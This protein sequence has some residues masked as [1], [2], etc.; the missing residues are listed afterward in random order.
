MADILFISHSA[1]LSGAPVCLLLLAREMAR[2]GHGV[3]FG[4]PAGGP[5]FDRYPEA[6]PTRFFGRSPGRLVAGIRPDLVHVNTVVPV[7][8]ARAARKAGIPVVWHIHETPAGMKSSQKRAL[9][10]MAGAV[11]VPSRDLAWEMAAYKLARPENIHA[12]HNG[13]A[14]G[15]FVPAKASRQS[16]RKEL[17]IPEDA[18]LAGTLGTLTPR[19]NL[20]GFVRAARVAADGVPAAFFLVAGDPAFR[21]GWYERRVKRLANRLGLAGRFRF[22]PARPDAAALLSALDLYMSAS[23]WEGLPLSVMEAMALGVPVAAFAS[24]GTPE[25]VRHRADGLLAPTGDE[26]ALGQA[27]A[28]ILSD[29]WFRRRAGREAAK[30]IAEDFGLSA[31]ADRVEAVYGKVLDRSAERGLP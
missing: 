4:A 14:P 26:K 6:V 25:L 19:K 18:L 5:L 13:L 12:I 9:R 21:E 28:E 17:S 31:H 1:N 8:A 20:E 27:V 11:I 23:L 24:G 16:V 10:R 2:R 3:L 30:R 22:L 29:D 15:E 7:R